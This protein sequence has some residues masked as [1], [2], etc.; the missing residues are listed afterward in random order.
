MARQIRLKERLLREA[1]ADNVYLIEGRPALEA[2]RRVRRHLAARAA[3]LVG[4]PAALA[5]LAL[6]ASELAG[7]WRAQ[8]A[9]RLA[10]SRPPIRV[11]AA[12]RPP[13]DLSASAALAVAPVGLPIG[14][15]VL[16][17]AVRRVVLDPGHGG[18]NRGAASR[19]GLVEKDLTL[20]IAQRLEALLTT[21]S[22]EVVLTRGGD[23]A[24]SLAERGKVANRGDGDIFVSIHV[25]WLDDPGARGVETF[26]LGPTDDPEL[27]AMAARENAEGGLRMADLREAI[28]RVY[29]D[30]RREES[31]ALAEAV[32]GALLVSLRTLDPDVRNRGVK[33]APFGVLIHTEMPAILAEVGCLSNDEESELLRDEGYRQYLAETLFRGIRA[34]TDALNRSTIRGS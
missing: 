4:V 2:R 26:Y 17:L 5:A 22:Y 7:A 24:L 33:S 27:E 1:V 29:A 11:E 32:Q 23:E 3:F 30:V 25:N 14:R 34:Y 6:A 28:E 9:S 13:H 10:A 21:A 18:A 31:R 19:D 16:P 20:D 12:P 15:S 8:A